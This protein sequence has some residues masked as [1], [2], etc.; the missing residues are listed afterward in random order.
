MKLTHCPRNLRVAEVHPP[1]AFDEIRKRD[2][3]LRVFLRNRDERKRLAIGANIEEKY[4]GM[5]QHE[6]VG[7]GRLFNFLYTH[8]GDRWRL[9]VGVGRRRKR[10]GKGRQEVWDE[11]CLFWGIIE[12]DEDEA[13]VHTRLGFAKKLT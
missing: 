3:T 12:F 2:N 10:G 13:F 5:L 8:H 9:H 11:R 4:A 1:E 6:Y 7:Y